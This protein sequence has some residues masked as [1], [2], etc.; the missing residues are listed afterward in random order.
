MLA[1]ENSST[2]G[3]L[4]A[5]GA[6]RRSKLRQVR[7]M[8]MKFAATMIRSTMHLAFVFAF[9]MFGTATYAQTQAQPQPCPVTAPPNAPAT[10]NAA[11]GN[12]ASASKTAKGTKTNPDTATQVSNEANSVSNSINSTANSAESTMKSL[13]GLFHKKK[14]APANANPCAP[15]AAPTTNSAAGPA[16]RPIGAQP[17]SGSSTGA[18]INFDQPF[19]LPAGTKVEATLLAPYAEGNSFQVSPHGVHAATL[20]HS[21]S[22]LQIIYDGVA[23]PVFDTFGGNQY[24]PVSFSPDGNHFGYCGIASEQFSV[25]VDGKQV[26]GG[27]QVNSNYTC[28]VYFSPDSRH[29]FYTMTTTGNGGDTYMRVVFDGKIE[30]RLGDFNPQSMTWSPDGDNFAMLVDSYPPVPN[31]GQQLV[32][33]GRP[34]PLPGGS[35]QWSADSKHLYTV[36]I[37]QGQ[38]QT[39][40]L[41]GKPLLT[42]TR[43]VLAIPPVGNMAVMAAFLSNGGRGGVLQEAW[44]LAVNGQRVPGSEIVRPRTGGGGQIGQI[45]ISP[46]GKHYAAICTSVTGKAYVFADG[47]RGLDYARIDKFVGFTAD[48]SKPVYVGMNGRDYLVIGDQESQL[49]DGGQQPVIAP[50]GDHVAAAGLGLTL[51]GQ[52]LNLAGNPP[53]SRT[54]AFS[55][56]PDGA[57]YAFLMQG[58]S[59]FTAFEDDVPQTAYTWIGNGNQAGKLWNGSHMAYFCG[60]ANPSGPDTYGLCVDGKFAYFGRN[61]VYE[62][63]T[64]SPDGSHVFFDD[65]KY[66]QGF[67]LFV[68]GQPVLD[69]FHPS[70]GWMPGTWEMEPDGTLEILTQDN[71]GLKRYSIT[72]SSS[73]SVMSLLGGSAAVASNH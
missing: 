22:R 40:F 10:A 47:K 65:N 63:L 30:L 26:G 31:A 16:A 42:A 43:I 60:L 52:P 11:N 69:G 2:G 37:R 29:F 15:A 54:S 62:N 45:F 50:T 66:A 35:P 71:T 53:T 68:D 64:F 36:G 19:T 12:A 7:E 67:R 73:T 17:A 46:D 6:L 61:P 70:P 13:G 20:A 59:S 38:G 56:S 49:P 41:D 21:G 14:A 34:S 27:P 28:N 8:T 44:Y 9:V 72:P 57:H 32:V 39:L 1:G 25:M 33:N 18:G 24:Q 3:H 23:G 58:R 48:S 5:M 51:D 55:Y 4:A